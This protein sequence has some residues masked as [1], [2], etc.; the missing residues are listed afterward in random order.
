MLPARIQ[1]GKLCSDVVKHVW[2]LTQQL[3]EGLLFFGKVREQFHHQNCFLSLRCMSALCDLNGKQ[4]STW[5][6]I[7]GEFPS[8]H[9]LHSF[10]TA[11]LEEGSC[12]ELQRTPLDILCS[13]IPP[14]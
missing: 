1:L 14:A 4:Q 8:A 5:F 12:W 11:N 6:L 2:V 10:N 13:V 9:P 3:M 7:Q